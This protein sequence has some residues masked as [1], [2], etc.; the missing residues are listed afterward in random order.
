MV[1]EPGKNDK[2]NDKSGYEDDLIIIHLTKCNIY[3]CKSL[4]TVVHCMAYKDA[5]YQYSNVSVQENPRCTDFETVN[6]GIYR[7]INNEEKIGAILTVTLMDSDK[8][9]CEYMNWNLHAQPLR[10]DTEKDPI[11][12]GNS[13]PSRKH[14]RIGTIS[15]TKP[16]GEEHYN[17]CEITGKKEY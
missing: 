1:L 10:K 2:N 16:N 15:Y 9:Q 4:K 8:Q 11:Q 13:S 12:D 3:Y 5:L 7:L 6:F 14:F 17:L